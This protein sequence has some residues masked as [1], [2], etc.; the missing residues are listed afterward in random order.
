LAFKGALHNTEA[1]AIAGLDRYGTPAARHY[2]CI[3][4]QWQP[5]S[6]NSCLFGIA[7]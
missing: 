2:A 5:N 1:G 3:E 4:G 7:A 6:L